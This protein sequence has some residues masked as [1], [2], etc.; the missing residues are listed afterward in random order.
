[1]EPEEVCGKTMQRADLSFL[2]LFKRPPGPL[3]YLISREMVTGSEGGHHVV[4]LFDHTNQLRTEPLFHFG[5]GF[6]GEGESHDLRDRQGA[7]FSHE[8][9]E[10]AIHEDRRLPGSRPR[11]HHDI[12]VPGGLG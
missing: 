10:D 11:D 4:S 3:D 7:W 5:S 6:V 12:A 9:I 1:M 2:D 8:K